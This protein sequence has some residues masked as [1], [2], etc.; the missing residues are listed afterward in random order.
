MLFLIWERRLL[1]GGE[2]GGGGGGVMVTKEGKLGD[3]VAAL[4]LRIDVAVAVSCL[5]KE[6]AVTALSCSV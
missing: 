6:M 1:C 5:N 3:D 2:G 4:L